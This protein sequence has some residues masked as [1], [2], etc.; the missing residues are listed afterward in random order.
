MEGN[1]R[2]KVSLQRED[3]CRETTATVAVKVRES[4]ARVSLLPRSRPT[5]THLYTSLPSCRSS[6]KVDTN[7]KEAT[8]EVSA[9]EEEEGG[10]V[11]PGEATEVLVDRPTSR[12]V[13]PALC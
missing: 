9:Q 3:G 1:F 7:S 8:T 10:E 6:L 4:R 12:T 5:I 13:S 2:S 11:P